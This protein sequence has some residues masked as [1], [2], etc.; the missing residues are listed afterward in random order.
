M[1]D[2]LSTDAQLAFLNQFSKT[3]HETIDANLVYE[4][5]RTLGV[6]AAMR[7]ADFVS[8]EAATVTYAGLSE[9]QLQTQETAQR[10]YLNF[11]TTPP[12]TRAKMLWHAIENIAP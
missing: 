8:A 9:A 5:E 6:D 7:Y 2:E 10:F 1:W 12:E 4:V 11:L 3:R